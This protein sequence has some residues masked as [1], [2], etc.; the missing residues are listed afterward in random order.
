MEKKCV[1]NIHVFV[2]VS[3]FRSVCVG[4]LFT[5]LMESGIVMFS[6]FGLLGEKSVRCDTKL[7]LHTYMFTHT[8]PVAYVC[9]D[10]CL[11]FT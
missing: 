1:H 3:V 6:N 4:G 10:H 2:F 9:Q 7:Q 5:I 8:Q 11:L